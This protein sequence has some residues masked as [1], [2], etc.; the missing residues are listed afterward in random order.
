MKLGADTPLAQQA[1]A[2]NRAT[3]RE[4]V[5]RATTDPQGPHLVVYDKEHLAIPNYGLAL[6]GAIIPQQDLGVFPLREL[7]TLEAARRS[8]QGCQACRKAVGIA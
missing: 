2:L 3:I 8:F 4:G 7:T 1:L 5:Q 6:C